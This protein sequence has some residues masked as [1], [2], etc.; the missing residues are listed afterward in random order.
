MQYW[1][2]ILQYCNTER[3]VWYLL[4]SVELNAISSSGHIHVFGQ[5]V[6]GGPGAS[7]TVSLVSFDW[8][9]DSL[10][11]FDWSEDSL[12]IVELSTSLSDVSK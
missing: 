4:L 10:V 2:A 1:F 5:V 12:V 9:E 8:S 6:V 3:L 11:S 7:V